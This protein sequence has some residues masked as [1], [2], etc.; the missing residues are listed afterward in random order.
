M[1]GGIKSRAELVR[2]AL[3]LLGILQA[4]QDPSAEDTDVVD[5]KVEP[6]LAGLRTLEIIEIGDPEAIPD[7]V[8]LQ[9]AAF[10]AE[11]CV[12]T[13][14]LMGAEAQRVS[15]ARQVAEQEIRIMTRSRPT[16]ETAGSEYF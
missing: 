10:L 2:E 16:Y 11:K 14:G 5:D 12:Q 15:D 4:G 7:E 1:A 6:T 13:F 8:F 9:V 3:D